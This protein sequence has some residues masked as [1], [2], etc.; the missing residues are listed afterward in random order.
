MLSTPKKTLEQI[1]ESGNDY[2]VAVKRNQ[3]RLY[4]HLQTYFQYLKPIAQHTHRE[5]RRGR[6]EHRC[7]KVYRPA[8]W[9]RQQWKA[10]ESVLCVERWG[11]RQ[12]KDYH[13]RAYYISSVVTSA[14]RWQALVREHWGIENRLHW[15]KDVVFAEDAYRLEDQQALLNGSL[16]R[17]IAINVLRLNGFHSLKTALTKLANRV[18][19]IFPLLT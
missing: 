13:H 3:G 15:P 17:T 14:H 1:I 11:T 12:G 16:F 19:L 7:V 6:C 4:Q 18:D 5:Q 8:D 2:L 9:A 10:I